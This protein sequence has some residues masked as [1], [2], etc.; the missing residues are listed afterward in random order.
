MVE[1]LEFHDAPD[2]AIEADK[3]KEACLEIIP[4]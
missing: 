1:I 4:I 2:E 3:A